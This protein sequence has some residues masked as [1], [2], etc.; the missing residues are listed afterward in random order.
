MS[1]LGEIHIKSTF[2]K[3][4]SNMFYITWCDEE[5][6]LLHRA[7]ITTFVIDIEQ[8]ILYQMHYYLDI[9]N[10]FILNSGEACFVYINADAEV[11]KILQSRYLSINI[12]KAYDAS[13][14]FGE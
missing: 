14:I 4:V 5:A 2:T 13:D 8:N 9:I 10:D 12:L 6:R 1:G 11:V 7:G 3:P